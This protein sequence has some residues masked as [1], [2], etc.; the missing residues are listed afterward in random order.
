M[1][2]AESC[3]V[4]KLFDS[5]IKLVMARGVGRGGMKANNPII[6]NII[7]PIRNSVYS[8]KFILIKLVDGK[9]LEEINKYNTAT[10]KILSNR[11]NVAAGRGRLN[12]WRN[13]M[14]KLTRTHT[15]TGTH[16]DTNSFNSSCEK[17]YCVAVFVYD[18]FVC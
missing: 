2:A 15:Q 3:S 10:K 13:T 9:A 12:Q 1:Y 18:I 16:A 6:H 8:I 17:L 5:I 14:N 4:R 11:V 7:S